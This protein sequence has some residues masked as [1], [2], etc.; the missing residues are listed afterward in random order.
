MYIYTY[1][2]G[3]QGKGGYVVTAGFGA[4]FGFENFYL[5]HVI[6]IY[7]YICMYEHVPKKMYIYMYCECRARAGMWRRGR[8][9][10]R[11]LG[12]R[13]FIYIMS[14]NHMYI[15]CHINIYFIYINV[16]K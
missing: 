14:Y 4:Y 9:L 1:T 5:Y 13:S 7:I 11:M 10:E 15:S 6:C 8:G 12:S 2:V 3:M 16:L